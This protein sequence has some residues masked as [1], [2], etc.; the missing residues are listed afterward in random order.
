MDFYGVEPTGVEVIDW[1]E[2]I[3]GVQK[4]IPRDMWVQLMK[5]YDTSIRSKK[6][7]YLIRGVHVWPAVITDGDTARLVKT[8]A[9][10]RGHQTQREFQLRLFDV[11]KANTWTGKWAG[12]EGAS[13]ACDVKWDYYGIEKRSELTIQSIYKR[14]EGLRIA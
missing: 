13:Y 9:V 10:G 5:R 1:A 4:K 2:F 14:I 6:R 11:I 8:V 3:Y 12:P 7:V